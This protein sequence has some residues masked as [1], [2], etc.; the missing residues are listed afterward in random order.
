MN[1]MEI[2][3]MEKDIPDEITDEIGILYKYYIA[4]VCPWTCA[5]QSG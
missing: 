3:D 5:S 1:D 2:D 4:C